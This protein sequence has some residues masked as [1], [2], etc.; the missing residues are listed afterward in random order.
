MNSLTNRIAISAL[1]LCA[2]PLAAQWS[3]LPGAAAPTVE[4]FHMLAPA[5]GTLH[6]FSAMAV[7]WLDL[8]TPD[9]LYPDPVRTGD[10]LALVRLSSQHYRAYSARLHRYSDIAFTDDPRQMIVCVDDDVIL[11]IGNRVG[12]SGLDACA[13]SAQTN[14]WDIVPVHEGYLDYACSRFVAGVIR[15]DNQ[16]FGFSARH[17]VWVPTA[18]GSGADMLADGNVLFVDIAPPGAVQAFS[19]VR[20]EWAISPSQHGSSSAAIDHNVAYVRVGTVLLGAKPCAYSAYGGAWVTTSTPFNATALLTDNVVLLERSST[21]AP[22]YRAFGARPGA[23]APLALGTG[24]TAVVASDDDWV[25]VDDETTGTLHAFGGLC[26]GAWS[27]EPYGGSIAV[28]TGPNSLALGRDSSGVVHTFSA[29]TGAFAAPLSMPTGA[30]VVGPAM[31]YAYDATQRRALAARH[32]G[33]IAGPAKDPLATYSHG[34]VGS[35]AAERNDLTGELTLWHERANAWVSVPV[36]STVTPT[37][38]GRRNVLIV[39][40]TAGGGQVFGLSAQRGN[41]VAAAGIVGTVVARGADENVGYVQDSGGNLHAF[42]SPNATHS[43]FQYP[44]DSEFQ[45]FADS[46]P[47]PSKTMLK[48]TPGAV[49]ALLI[50]AAPLVPPLVLPGTGTLYCDILTGPYVVVY[51]PA[52]GTN[53]LLPAPITLTLLG[54]PACFELCSQGLTLAGSFALLGDAAEPVRF[55]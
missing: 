4:A 44:L 37:Y 42:G 3:V 1:A 31:A 16:G 19:G 10:W 28:L 38:V 36:A 29:A 45:A 26:G 27:A 51:G 48:G 6:A 33:W 5:G 24:A 40:A 21:G 34:F 30:V 49:T 20:G 39:D 22:T 43:W 15:A 32:G 12:G 53:G 2:A 41:L 8:G 11:M 13:Y 9:T 47:I 50:S 52:I 54:A 23:W 17:G 55:H 35:L 46:T 14:T 7:G 25:V 18:C